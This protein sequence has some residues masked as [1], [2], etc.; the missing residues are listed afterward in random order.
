MARRL[1]CFLFLLKKKLWSNL[2]HYCLPPC[3][4][5]KRALLERDFPL[6]R[7]GPARST[8][9]PQRTVFCCYCSVVNFPPHLFSLSTPHSYC[10]AIIPWDLFSVPHA[11]SIFSGFMVLFLVFVCFAL[12]PN[13]FPQSLL[14]IHQCLRVRATQ[15]VPSQWA[16]QARAQFDWR[17]AI[18]SN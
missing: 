9:H 13:H 16:D 2:Y 7:G 4:C 11:I 15:V 14:I 1:R 3:G 12:S 10:V 5:W 18:Q 17:S 8:Q 6:T